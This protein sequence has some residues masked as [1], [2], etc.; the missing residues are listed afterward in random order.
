MA[1]PEQQRHRRWRVL[2]IVAIAASAVIGSVSSAG[3]PFRLSAPSGGSNGATGSAAKSKALRQAEATVADEARTASVNRT[4]PS[5][6]PGNNWSAVSSGPHGFVAGKSRLLASRTTATSTTYANPDGTL[7][8]RLYQS[9][10]NY[11][12]ADGSWHA[13]DPTLLTR[14]DGTIHNTAGPV[15]VAFASQIGAGPLMTVTSG[16]HSLS[17][18]PPS[19]GTASSL[20][21]PALPAPAAITNWDTVTY[22]NVWPGVDLQFSTTLHTVKALVILHAAPQISGDLDLRFPL[23][24][25]GLGVG[26]GAG[27]SIT[28]ADALGNPQFSFPLGTMADSNV[29]PHSGNSPTTNLSYSLDPAGRF[30]D[31]IASRA[32]LDDPARVYPVNIDPST[33]LYGN[34]DDAYVADAYPTSNYHARYDSGQSDYDDWVGYYD[35]STGTNWTMMGFDT[36]PISGD[37]IISATWWGY[38][39]WSSSCSATKYWL[40]RA[41]SSWS[42]TGVTWNTHPT[43]SS[44]S[45]TGTVAANWQGCGSE[46]RSSSTADIT[47]WVQGWASGTYPN[48]GLVLNENENGSTY[49]KKLASEE[50]NI[51]GGGYP[52]IIVNYEVLGPVNW[53]FQDD[54]Q[55]PP[56]VPINGNPSFLG[57]D[58][59][60]SSDMWVYVVNDGSNT[61]PANG[62][63]RL[64][65][66]LYDSSGSTLLQ[67]NGKGTVLPT[68]VVPGNGIWLDAQIDSFA[69]SGVTSSGSYSIRWDMVEEGVAWFSDVGVATA[70]FRVLVTTP[71]APSS[72]GNGSTITTLTPTLSAG[73]CTAC[74]NYQFALSTDSGF[75]RY[76]VTS[77]WS[78]TASWAL[79]SGTLQPG[80]TYYW[81][82]I[83]RDSHKASSSWSSS[84]SFS[85]AAAPGTPS[86][87][88]ASGGSGQASLSWTAPGNGGSPISG[89]SV[90]P[91]LGGHPQTPVAEPGGSS[92]ATLTGLSNGG[93]YMFTVS[94][95]NAMGAGPTSGFSNVVT[96]AGAPGVPG[97]VAAVAGNG[98]ISASWAPAAGNGASVSGYTVDAYAGGNLVGSVTVAGTASTAQLTQ[99]IVNG[100]AY[101]VTVAA[102]NA[103]GTGA[104]SPATPAVTAAPGPT[105]GLSLDSGLYARGASATATATVTPAGESGDNGVRVVFA[106]AAGFDGLGASTQVNG[107]SCAA[108]GVSCSDTAGSV[109]V[110]GL[111]LPSGGATVSTTFRALGSD[112]LC[113]P[114]GITVTASNGA[115]AGAIAGQSANVC[116]GGL[117]VQRW[118]RLVSDA[119]SAGGAAEVNAANGNLELSQQD[120]TSFQLHG[121]LTLGTNRAY[122]SET[123]APSNAETLGLGW[124]TSWVAAGDSLGGV[125]LR[126]PSDE[127]AGD[128]EA[129]TLI[130]DTGARDVF[131]PQYLATPVD[132]TGLGSSTG[133]LGPLQPTTLGLDSGYNRVCVDAAYSPEPGVHASMWRYIET[134]NGTCNGGGLNPKVLGYATLTIDR[135]R[136]EFSADGRLLSVRDAAGNRVD[137]S[138]DSSERLTR[139]GETGGSSRA[140]SLT[141]TTWASGPEVD[142][143]DPAQRVTE[144]QEDS[145]GHL[146]N[147]VNPNGAGTLAY[148]YGGCGGSADQLCSAADA[149]GHQ[150]TLQYSAAPAGPA[151]LQRL[152]D[153]VNTTTSFSYA[154]DGSWTQADTGTER[155]RFAEIDAL[156]RVGEFDEGDTSG[157]WARITLDS[158]DATGCRQPDSAPDN[159]LCDAVRLALDNGQTPDGNIAYVYNDEGG[160]IR[161]DESASPSPDIVTTSGYTSQYVEADGTVR[162]FSDSIAGQGVVNSGTAGRRD[163][164]TLFVLSDQTA[165][166][167]GDGNAVTSGFS[168]YLTSYAVDATS[169]VGAGLP[170]GSTAP[171]AG[172][173]DNSGLL[174]QSTGP[175]KD[176]VHATTTSYTYDQNGQRT[177]L[178]TPDENAGAS[179]AAYVYTY[180]GD[181]GHG[182]LAGTT[183]PGGWLKAISDPDGHFVGFG[184]DAAGNVVRTWDRDATAGLTLSAIPGT[185]SSPPNQQYTET[186]YGSGANAYSAPWRYEVSSRDPLGNLTSYTVD[187][188]GDRLAVRPPL[189]NVAG[190]SSYDVTQAFDADGNLVCSLTPLE[191]NGGTTCSAYVANPS[192]SVHPTLDAYDQYG[193]LSASTDPDGNVTT[194]AYDAVNRQVQ[195]N[196]TRYVDNQGVTQ[197]AGCRA[198]TSADAPIPSGYWLCST[199]TT[200][201]GADNLTASSDA[202]P[203]NDGSGA[204]VSTQHLYDAAHRVVTTYT[205]RYDGTLRLLRADTVYDADGNVTVSCPPRHFTESS[206]ACGAS[207]DYFSTYKTYNAADLL[208]SSLVYTDTSG[209]S[210]TTTYGYDADGNQLVTT[211]ANE[212]TSTSAYDLLD[213]LQST[214][215]PQDA[216]HS[217]VTSYLYDP[218]G[219]RTDT[220]Q[221][222]QSG[223][224]NTLVSYDADNRPLDAVVAAQTSAG[225]PTTDITQVGT[226]D[227]SGGVN[228]H[229]RNVYDADGNLVAQYSPRAFASSA[230]NPNPEFMV[231]TDYDKDGRPFTQWVP[232]YDIS[233]NEQALGVISVW[234]GQ[235]S[236]ATDCPTGQAGHVNGVADFPTTTGVCVTEV[237]YDAAG[238][239]VKEL[240]PTAAGSWSS[241]RVDSFVYTNDGLVYE[242]ITADPSNDGLTVQT[243]SQYDAD[244]NLLSASDPI[245]VGSNPTNFTTYAWSLDGLNTSIID[246]AGPNGQPHTSAQGYDAAGNVI[247]ASDSYGATTQTAYSPNNLKILVTAPG[248]GVQPGGQTTNNSPI[249]TSYIYDAVGNLRT[250]V[251][252]NN[253]QTTYTYTDNNLLLQTTYPPG[254]QGV[255]RTVSNTYDQADERLTQ[256][257]AGNSTETFAYFLDGRLSSDSTS[258]GSTP[259]KTF[260]YD[261]DGNTTG[262]TEGSLTGTSS[263]YIDG[264]LRTTDDTGYMAEWSYDGSGQMATLHEVRDGGTTQT[265]TEAA[266]YTNDGQLEDV[267][268]HEYNSGNS[269]Q[270]YA[271]SYLGQPT[272]ITLSNSDTA[273]Y[274][275]NSDNSLASIALKQSNGTQVAT[276]SYAYDENFQQLYAGETAPNWASSSTYMYWPDGRIAQYGISSKNFDT[277]VNYDKDGNRT[278][279]TPPTTSTATDSTYNADDS[280]ATV[281]SGSTTLTVAYDAY[282]NMTN[283]GCTTYAYDGFNRMT[284]ATAITSNRPTLCGTAPTTNPTY[285]Y[286]AL[287]RQLTHTD[288]NGYWWTHYATMGAEVGLLQKGQEGANHTIGSGELDTQMVN[289]P[290]GVATQ[291][292]DLESPYTSQWLSDNGQGSLGVVTT[293]NS[294]NSTCLLQYDLYGSNIA[295]SSSSNPCIDGGSQ[296]T[297][298]AYRFS[299][300]DGSTGDYQFG[301]RTYDPSKSA[302]TA[303]DAYTPGN[304]ATDLSIGVDPITQDVYS[305]VNGDPVNRIDPTGHRYTTGCEDGGGACYGSRPAPIMPCSVRGTCSSG[306]EG[307]GSR[308]YGSGGGSNQR[309]RATPR[310][311]RVAP[312]TL[313][314]P[315]QLSRLLRAHVQL[316]AGASDPSQPKVGYGLW[317]LC[318]YSDGGNSVACPNA[319]GSDTLTAQ[320][321]VP[322]GNVNWGSLALNF[323]INAFA[324]ANLEDG[325]GEAQL[326]A[327]FGTP[328]VSD[329]TEAAAT[330]AAGA[331]NAPLDV[332]QAGEQFVRVGASPE[333]LN[334]TYDSLGGTLPRTYAF[335]KATFD[336]IGND[337]AAL[338]NL[339]DLPGAPPTVYRILEPPA[340]TAIQRGIVPGGV[341]GGAGGVPEVFF[342]E[343]W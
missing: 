170:I 186:M 70:D 179:G 130:D 154:A 111:T 12:T 248:G 267:R 117:G 288:T 136:R 341:F 45:A 188:N 160:V 155:R 197:P 158:F 195:K 146:L 92:G 36:S 218:S 21:A 1:E 194:Y 268:S 39:E 68:A 119:V 22:K 94:A 227:Q 118:W 226:T 168:G 262:W 140:Y 107:G 297:E 270:H 208:T 134:Q 53:G 106:S 209:T 205:P 60:H 283:D 193:N 243:I 266:G 259:A 76:V 261:A 189:G 65:Y 2:L 164:S 237:Q 327:E 176:G 244:G 223:T 174:C 278:A 330:D 31:L 308:V 329:A 211:D 85:V 310:A 307:S 171:C 180:Y 38:F 231:R 289:G 228:I 150:V 236:Q 245:R 317:A 4:H 336:W 77:P 319:E 27:G 200:Y 282:G 340:G 72:P 133:P 58:D 323:A 137:F 326:A 88:S 322:G 339:G 337:P 190:D 161:K 167:T 295:P 273:T 312:T 126:V 29:D 242:A 20:T 82:V 196:W 263:Y 290:D 287:D 304:T 169:S 104:P 74:S 9:A 258:R 212:H 97:S 321:Y 220:T 181:N 114:A 108:A 102:S 219:N 89:Y 175:Q 264:L 141:Y 184:Y 279:W 115:G 93:A 99:G 333:N 40:W 14:P 35:S 192:S 61:W 43:H 54:Q 217:T 37:K 41:T 335:D 128:A 328:F 303:P 277:Y 142:V 101:T 286:D 113:G 253:K 331:I 5:A 233:D 206:A 105:V 7:T 10:V 165:S 122:N 81:R 96:P 265:S 147:V 292:L 249:S 33:N 284:S 239:V 240:L 144:Y 311:T 305:Y 110:S 229:S 83:G 44:D 86:G 73:T 199:T 15:D 78:S 55:N 69:N 131:E 50:S 191:S 71:P 291:V 84:D 34:A 332:T 120:S 121:Q 254:Y 230:T 214:T 300:R 125:A 178:T 19:M 149:L 256:T 320:E 225:V 42:A 8:T 221:T 216:T 64:S 301:K 271:Y 246:P 145:S 198:S 23:S 123:V 257:T 166:L 3:L 91:Y 250:G 28:F 275:Y 153:R 182:D 204:T 203:A 316:E 234:S 309:G 109:T 75:N 16:S 235:A 79:P 299:Q 274:G 90:T 163:A 293:S 302:F 18:F 152:T 173:G 183:N 62:N 213:R 98:Q 187:N 132:V 280:L 325:E 25:S 32:W 185:L 24:F 47:S 269:G 129:V 177:S 241:L 139:V 172:G 59:T 116:D 127:H 6:I 342:P 135:V 276:W 251:S 272:S 215:V 201:D 162:T 95:S 30:V 26:A 224:R 11:Q 238:R 100:T 159:N 57:P 334:A 148:I 315:P 87:V 52:S 210:A 294:G 66:H 156:G 306:G 338:K 324:I 298:L 281:K 48:Y 17:I 13:I 252:A 80:T 157:N 56:V 67:W 112:A 313:P 260:T 314:R 63:Y 296:L 46:Q 151:R 103:V 202:V 343:G 124:T 285:T 255:Q 207:S 138:Y 51:G 318:T 49:W 232:R 247:S 222:P 143:K